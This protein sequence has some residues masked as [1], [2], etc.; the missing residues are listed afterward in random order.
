MLITLDRSKEITIQ[1]GT[2]AVINNIYEVHAVK[3]PGETEPPLLIWYMSP[4]FQRFPRQKILGPENDYPDRLPYETLEYYTNSG[5]KAEIYPVSFFC[6]TG[7]IMRM[8]N[9][10]EKHGD[11]QVCIRMKCQVDSDTEE[12]FLERVDL[13]R[14]LITPCEVTVEKIEHKSQSRARGRG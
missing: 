14:K 2:Q 4:Y 11:N 6:R 12:L 8:I 5:E 7:Q 13:L 3:K 10:E 9:C 1:P